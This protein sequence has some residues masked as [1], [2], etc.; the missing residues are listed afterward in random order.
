MKQ[1]SRIGVG[2]GDGND[3]ELGKGACEAKS[4]RSDQKYSE[5]ILQ[6]GQPQPTPQPPT[7]ILSPPHDC[8]HNL[9]SHSDQKQTN[10]I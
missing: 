6:F 7:S 3:N 5:E 1:M 9:R 4:I 2:S 8:S 10:C